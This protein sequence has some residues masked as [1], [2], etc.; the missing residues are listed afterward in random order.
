LNSSTNNPL[1]QTK[2]HSINDDNITKYYND[3]VKSRADVLAKTQ[4]FSTGPSIT[5]KDLTKLL[6]RP[7]DAEGIYA[8]DGSEPIRVYK[9]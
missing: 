7:Y 1:A 2:S 8:N 5:D 9:T 4:R 6:S 3:I